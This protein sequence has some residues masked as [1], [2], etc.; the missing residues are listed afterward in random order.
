MSQSLT[1]ACCGRF[2]ARVFRGMKTIL[3]TGWCVLGPFVA[4]G[5]DPGLATNKVTLAWDRSQS[6]NI[7][8]YRLYRGLASQVYTDLVDVGNT[9]NA[10]LSDLSLGTNYFFAVTAYD[11]IGLESP[12]SN[13]I[14]YTAG[15]P[16]QSRLQISAAPPSQ[17]TLKASGP[18]GY[19]YDVLMSQGLS[20]WTTITN[21]SL[22]TNGS[23]LYSPP[24][25]ISEPPRYYKLLQTY[26]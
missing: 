25:A 1:L 24:P 11:I 6:A 12:F 9:T 10:T 5:A 2:G 19:R 16:L 17:V 7:A 15:T 26:P 23:V 14:S 18:S 22:D 20:D 8:G 3:V 4:L 13:E 21:I